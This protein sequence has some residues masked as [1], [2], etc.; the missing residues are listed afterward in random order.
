M[1]DAVERQDSAVLMILLGFKEQGNLEFRQNET[2]FLQW[3]G[4]AKDNITIPGEKEVI[5]AIERGY[6]NYLGE[7]STLRLTNEADHLRAI[8]V[9]HEVVLPLF[10]SVR[11]FCIKLRDLN[12]ETM[13]AASNRAHKLAVQAVFSISFIGLAAVIIGILFSLFLTRLISRPVTEL[14]E[15]VSH[16][17]Q[18]DYEIQVPVRGTGE[19]ALLAQQFNLMAE[20]L[21]HYHAMNVGEIIAEKRKSEAIIQSVDDG[22]VVVDDSLLISA[23]NPKAATIFGVNRDE[24]QGR[25][26][27]EVLREEKFLGFIKQSLASGTPPGFPKGKIFSRSSSRAGISIFTAPSFPCGPRLLKPKGSFYSCG[28][29]PGSTNWTV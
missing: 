18:R 11:D 3:L 5:E 9:Y 26:I 25:H 14:S 15:A 22:L 29:L 20:K 12:H 6:T 10:R 8:K 17:A 13:Y 19:L 4:R 16:I 23:I 27:L 7:V 24:S 21:R 1:I 28:T 2:I